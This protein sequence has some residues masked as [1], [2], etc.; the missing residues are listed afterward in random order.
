MLESLSVS[1]LG[2]L[3]EVLQNPYRNVFDYF[4]KKQ[5]IGAMSTQYRDA[6]FMENLQNAANMVQSA[7][8]FIYVTP[9]QNAIKKSLPKSVQRAGDIYDAVNQ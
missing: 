9:A 4:D 2:A 1:E 6:H 3:G 5:M 7:M 8:K